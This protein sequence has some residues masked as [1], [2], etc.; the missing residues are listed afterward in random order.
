MTQLVGDFRDCERARKKTQV[1][2]YRPNVTSHVYNYRY[3]S[4]VA[5][6]AVNNVITKQI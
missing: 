5:V 1:Y 3:V 6:T 2:P 4:Q